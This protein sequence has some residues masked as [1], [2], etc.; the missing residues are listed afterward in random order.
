MADYPGS[1]YQ[2]A[3]DDFNRTDNSSTGM[4]LGANWTASVP[5]SDLGIISNTAYQTADTGDNAAFYSASTFTND[6]Y[7][8]VTLTDATGASG[9]GVRMSATDYVFGQFSSPNYKIYWYNAGAYTQIATGAGSVANGDVLE[10]VAVNQTFLLY[11]NSTLVISGINNSAPS[12][13]KPGIVIE[14]PSSRLDDWSGGEVR[15]L[16]IKGVL[17]I[18]GIS[19]IKSN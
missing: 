2:I 18:K 1:K 6:Q 9:V 11:K 7:S 13:G 17:S 14:N 4:N 3:T 16:Q 15:K 5:N 8:K 19:S 12:T 10:I